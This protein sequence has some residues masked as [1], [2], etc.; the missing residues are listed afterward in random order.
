MSCSTA[1]KTACAEWRAGT[2]RTP[3]NH[4]GPQSRRMRSRI[5]TLA[6]AD[7]GGR[8]G[9]SRT[10]QWLQ[11]KPRRGRRKLSQPSRAGLVQTLSDPFLFEGPRASGSNRST[12][13]KIRTISPKSVPSM[14]NAP[15]ALS[16][17]R[18][19]D[20]DRGAPSASCFGARR[21]RERRASI[22]GAGRPAEES[23]PGADAH[24]LAVPGAGD[25]VR[26]D[27]PRMFID[28]E[29]IANPVVD[30]RRLPTAA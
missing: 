27:Q 2:V 12:N 1:T 25:A 16:S 20:R 10:S 24:L 4:R 11:R 7:V 29:M 9:N 18:P 30:A 19:P 8:G 22:G 5:C 23:A 3:P 14:I 26:G 6:R 28:W 15:T 13:A 17:S 21:D